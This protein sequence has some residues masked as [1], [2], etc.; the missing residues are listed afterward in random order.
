MR[1]DEL[2]RSRLVDSTL[3][4]AG[5][6]LELID[7][8]TDRKEGP[9]LSWVGSDY[10]PNFVSLNKFK[11]SKMIS[12]NKGHTSVKNETKW[13]SNDRH[14]L[15]FCEGLQSTSSILAASFELCKYVPTCCASV[16]LSILISS[17]KQRFLIYKHFS[18]QFAM[19][20]FSSSSVS[21]CDQRAFKMMSGCL[22]SYVNVLLVAVEDY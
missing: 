18:I 12:W 17:C 22:M 21:V 19:L 6:G 2:G 7:W 20:S 16:Y 5:Y 8:F 10:V 11:W 9:Q 14:T 1:I 15:R 4:S 3:P 13:I